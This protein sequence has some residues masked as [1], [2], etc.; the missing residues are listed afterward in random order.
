M[1]LKQ[2]WILIH[3]RPYKMTDEKTGQI[4]EG[5]SFNYLP[6]ENFTPLVDGD[7]RGIKPCKGSL[8][9]EKM[10]NVNNVPG[11]YEFTMTMSANAQG[12][13][14]LKVKDLVYISD[15]SIIPEKSR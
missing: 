8:P 10:A 3:A 4:N 13:A 11:I 2:K 6:I 15:I 1:D 12:K 7:G 5:V 14:E 9:I